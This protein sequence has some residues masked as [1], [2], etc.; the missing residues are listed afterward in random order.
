MTHWSSLAG[1]GCPHTTNEASSRVS[2]PVIDMLALFMATLPAQP[3]GTANEAVVPLGIM[4]GWMGP[5][6]GVGLPALLAWA[7]VISC[8]RAKVSFLDHDL[9]A[10]RETRTHQILTVRV[11]NLNC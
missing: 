11:E 10:G 2:S 1:S 3:V 5:P 9:M 4:P 7:V 8:P 6:T